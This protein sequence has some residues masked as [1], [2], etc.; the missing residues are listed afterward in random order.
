M[1][2]YTN[3]LIPEGFAGCARGPFI[4]IRPEFKDDK[5]LLAH[6]RTHVKQWVRTLGLHSLL[7][8]LSSKYKL[9]CEIEAYKK[10]LEF[11]P[12]NKDLFAYF[13]SVNY[14]LDI[15]KEEAYKLL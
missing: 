14:G 8:V 1:T 7:Y 13:I 4:F 3:R 10:Q 9:N 11:S 15:T 12:N 2:F 5:G 6:E